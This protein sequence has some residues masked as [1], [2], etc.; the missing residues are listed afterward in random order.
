MK[1]VPL[2]RY[3]CDIAPF[4]NDIG[5]LDVLNNLQKYAGVHI[6]LVGVVDWREP[7]VKACCFLEGDGPL[8]V[9][10]YETIEKLDCASQT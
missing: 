5:S 6:E 4:L 3:F 9:D 1:H 10:C 8:A 7:F 2:F